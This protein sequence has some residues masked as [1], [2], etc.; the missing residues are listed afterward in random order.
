MA[1]YR[2]LS[3]LAEVKKAMRELAPKLQRRYMRPAIADGARVIRNE[4][5]ILA[6]VSDGMK[7]AGRPRAGTLRR[8]IILKYIPEASRG[9]RVTYYVT[10][11]RGKRFQAMKRRRGGKEVIL[12]EDAYY[13]FWVE[14]GHLA[15]GPGQ[16]VAGGRRR[17]GRERE[18][19]KAGG[20]RFIPPRPYMRPAFENKK[21]EAIAAIRDR[22]VIG[23]KDL[24]REARR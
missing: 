7:P 24:A 8:N 23:L 13:W 12:N 14:F 3:G 22:L 18:R 19:L 20:A 5:R 16:K 9:S 4:A 10:V 17:A 21:G 1:E 2:H 6:P 15:R 11:K